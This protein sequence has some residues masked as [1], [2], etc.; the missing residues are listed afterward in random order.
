MRLVATQGTQTTGSS[1]MA[2]SHHV[3]PKVAVQV[4]LSHQGQ[5]SRPPLPVAQAYRLRKEQR[6]N[7]APEA[8]A[9]VV[10]KSRGSMFFKGHTVKLDK[11]PFLQRLARLG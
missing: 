1:D 4:R 6:E 7:C 3:T 11:D 10:E 2:A 5:P 8:P 9:P